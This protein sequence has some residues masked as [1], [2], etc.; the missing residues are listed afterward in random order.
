MDI[1]KPARY[2]ELLSKSFLTIFMKKFEYHTKYIDLT[3]EID[4]IKSL[5]SKTV[6]LHIN[7][8]TKDGVVFELFPIE[9]KESKEFFIDY[10]NQFANDKG[11]SF[12]LTLQDI[13]ELDEYFIVTCAK[14]NKTILSL[15][16]YIMNKETNMIIFGHSASH[17]RFLDEDTIINRNFIGRANRF[18]HFQDMIYFKNLGFKIYNLSG[19]KLNTTIVDLLN[20]NKFKDGFRGELVEQSHYE[21]YSLVIMKFI[22][23]LIK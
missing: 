2:G 22:N 5:F 19:Y 7:R 11:L 12:S 1:L 13:E 6:K 8:A 23:K 3:I 20:V 9:T 16:G 21:T 14:Y 18:L 17:F 10:Y 15:H 4:K